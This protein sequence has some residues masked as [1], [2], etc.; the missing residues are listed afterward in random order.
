[1]AVPV[2]HLV[3]HSE[4]VHPVEALSAVLSAVLSELSVEPLAVVL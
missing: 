2:V 1:L 4:V 3:V